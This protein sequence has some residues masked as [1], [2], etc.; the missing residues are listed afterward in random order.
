M[1]PGMRWERIMRAAL[2]TSALLAMQG[3][4]ERPDVS[5]APAVNEPSAQVQDLVGR[6]DNSD[7]QWDGTY[8][9]LMPRITGTAASGLVSVGPPAYPALMAALRDAKKFAAAHVVLTTIRQGRYTS[10]ASH[11]NGLR[12]TLKANGRT[13]LYPEQRPDLQR[14]WRH[15]L[16]V[17]PAASTTTRAWGTAS[18]TTTATTAPVAS[19]VPNTPPPAFF[20]ESDERV[21]ERFGGR[22]IP[23]GEGFLFVRQTPVDG[24]SIDRALTEEELIELFPTIQRMDPYRLSVDL[25]AMTDRTVELFNRLRSVREL[26]LGNSRVTMA[27]LRKLRLKAGKTLTLPQ[28]IGQADRRELEQL[29]PGVKIR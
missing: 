12:V 22:F 17:T 10:S 11:W 8:V 1:L 24:I 28:T 13:I 23:T 3:C 7:V 29:M 18:S 20:P 6:L 9:G 27:G 16:G 2:L 19:S 5:V 21:L 4:A 14:Y 25:G 15:Q 26:Y